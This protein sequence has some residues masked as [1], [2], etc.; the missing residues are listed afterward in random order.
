MLKKSQRL[1]KK[2]IERFFSGKFKSCKLGDI[3]LRVGKNE[4][5]AP[6]FAFIVSSSVKRNAVARNLTRRRMSEISKELSPKINNGL[7][8]VF[9]FKLLS[10]KAPSFGVLKEDMEKLLELSNIK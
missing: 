6:R 5:S 10:K 3:L 2:D 4:N 7:D 1:T 8:L 9:S